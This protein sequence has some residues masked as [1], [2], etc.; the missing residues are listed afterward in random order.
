MVDVEQCVLFIPPSGGPFQ[1]KHSRAC[2]SD[3]CAADY[4][5]DAV[6]RRG[7]IRSKEKS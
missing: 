3:Y 1:V 2:V 6:N 7:R 5:A 4:Q